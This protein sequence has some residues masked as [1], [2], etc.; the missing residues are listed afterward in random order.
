MINS[1]REASATGLRVSKLR[2]AAVALA[3][4]N[5]FG[6]RTN[7]N[8]ISRAL[9]ATNTCDYSVYCTF[10]CVGPSEWAFRFG[11]SPVEGR[12][13]AESQQQV[14]EG[15]CWVGQGMILLQEVGKRA[16]LFPSQHIDHNDIPHSITSQEAMRKQANHSV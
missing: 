5:L 7:T 1:Q 3:R 11:D 2:M 15:L 9:T 14:E 12:D 8:L 4:F 6:E 16:Q 13:G 10:V